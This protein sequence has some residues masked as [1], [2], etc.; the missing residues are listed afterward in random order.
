MVA[1][2]GFSFL[3]SH[4][5]LASPGPSNL[6]SEPTKYVGA[7]CCNWEPI[8]HLSG[9]PCS[10]LVLLWG[11]MEEWMLDS[12]KTA[13]ARGTSIHTFPRKSVGLIY[14]GCNSGPSLVWHTSEAS[15]QH[16]GGV[17]ERLEKFPISWASI[18][19]LARLRAELSG[20]DFSRGFPV[21]HS[22]G[23]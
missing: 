22:S 19:C 18:F 7:S 6:G 14:S 9:E 16:A 11:C 20:S 1:G 23:R 4:R 13:K 3:L 15:E 5:L 12:W 21:P 8:Y 17:C 10:L 2:A